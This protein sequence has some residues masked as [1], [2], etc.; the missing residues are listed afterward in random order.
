MH[1]NKPPQACLRALLALAAA[2]AFLAGASW[3]QEAPEGTAD[4]QPHRVPRVACSIKADGVLDEPCWAEALVMPVAYEVRPGENIPAPVRT[5]VLLAYDEARL[6]VAFRAYDP[7]PAL[8]RARLTDRD[9][10]WDDDWVCINLDTFNDERRSFLFLCNPLGVQADIIENEGS[11]SCPF[12]AIWDSGGRI[13]SE[14]YFVEM[15]IPFRALRFQR[16]SEDQVWGVD[17]IRS[18]PRDVRYHIGLFPRDRNNNCYLCQADKIVG[19]AGATPG[20]SLEFDPTVT[21]T[22]A[23]ARQGDEAVP[24]GDFED[25]DN[26]VDVGITGM[27][28]FTPNLT[29]CGTVNPDFSQVE[30]DAP[31]LDVNTQYALYYPE[32]RPFFLEGMNMF[33]SRLGV[34]YTRTLADPDWGVKVTGTEGRNVIGFFTVEDA[35]TNFLFPSAY[36]S[37]SSSLA[38]KAQGTVLRY[39]R[40]FSP[41]ASMGLFITD[42]EGKDYY[43]RLASLDGDFRITQ[44]DRVRFQ[45]LGTET[46]YPDSLAV[47]EE[48]P[49]GE[50]RGSGIDL[51]YFH[52]TSTLDWYAM[53]RRLEPG[54]RADLGYRPQVDYNFGEAG[55]GYTFNR[56]AGSWWTM[57]NIGGSYQYEETTSHEL[58]QKGVSSWFNYNGPR[59][60]FVNLNAY[61]GENRYEGKNYDI[62]RL[63]CEGGLWLTSY[64]FVMVWGVGGDQIDYENYRPG[65]GYTIEPI[66]NLKLGRHLEVQYEHTYERLDVD[67]GRLYTAGVDYLRLVYQFNRRTFV[68]AIVQYFD[69]DYNSD[70]Y[71]EER[72]SE[73]KY[74]FTQLL[75][76]YKINP[77]TVFYL[78]YSDDYLGNQ[79]YPLKQADRT[80]FAKIGY[81]LIL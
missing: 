76:S 20:H 81:A 77:Q 36:Y 71:L 28:G 37:S 79:D 69:Y 2:T 52:N 29:L 4:R 42:R 58:I 68:R 56:G 65:E 40:D 72:D 30:A 25:V 63:F 67:E 60:A 38:Q 62:N 27:W 6:Y 66:V 55:F 31:Q 50:F 19:F 9:L 14:G 73:E 80:F 57:L 32:R 15:C 75:F 41:S 26:S 23:Q 5:E 61:I 51:Y 22:R 59:E 13:T 43:N 78:G 17:A 7:E 33:D 49:E 24:Q 8:I 11:S 46:R 53:V 35:V 10:I 64:L 74:V 3:A 21:A 34:V 1:P 16:S 45:V 12:D 39:R 70:L 47:E 18:Y 44:K 54:I 48:Q